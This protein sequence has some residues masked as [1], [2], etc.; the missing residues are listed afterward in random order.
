V[1]ISAYD[2]FGRPAR[3]QLFPTDPDTPLWSETEWTLFGQPLL[4]RWGYG[5]TQSGLARWE[6]DGLFLRRYTDPRGHHD[7]WLSFK[8]IIQSRRFQSFYEGSW[9][10]LVRRVVILPPDL[11]EE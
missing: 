3:V 5:T 1:Q 8:C 2:L 10:D 7:G 9:E 4:A 11:T 6:W